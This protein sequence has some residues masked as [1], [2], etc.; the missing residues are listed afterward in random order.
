VQERRTFQELCEMEERERYLINV[1]QEPAQHSNAR[2][3]FETPHS[4]PPAFSTWNRNLEFQKKKVE[5]RSPETWRGRGALSDNP[6]KTLNTKER[7]T[8][9]SGASK[10]DNKEAGVVFCNPRE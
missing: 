1:V 10:N 9:R 5:N 3:E 6:A 2:Q 4:P 8:T 7:R